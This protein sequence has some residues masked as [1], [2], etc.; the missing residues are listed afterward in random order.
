M[1]LGEA[2][3]YE[4]IKA[5]KPFVGA[6]GRELDR[7]LQDSGI[8]RGD[9]WVSNVSKYLVPFNERGDKIPF[10]VRAKNVGI[11]LNKELEDLQNEINQIRPN[12]I[13]AL[14]NTALWALSGKT[15]ISQ[16]RGSILH[17][18][19]RKFVST[20]HPA[21]LLHNSKVGGVKG[22]WNRQIM[23]L[24]M[25]RVKLQSEFPE[26]RL[27]VR[28]LEICRSSIQLEEFLKQYEGKIP[29]VD[30]EAGGHCLPVCI[31]LAFNKSHGMT[32]PL[33][34]RDGIST[35]HDNELARIWGLLSDI[36]WRVNGVIGQNFNYDRDKILRLGFQVKR[37]KEDT[38]FKAFAINPELPKGLAFNTSIYTEEPYYKDEG[39]YEGSYN[40]L[41]TGCARDSCVTRELC[42]NMDED[43]DGINQRKYYENYLMKLPYMYWKIEQQGFAIDSDRRNELLRKYIERDEKLR[44]DMFKLVGIEVNPAS[45]KQM[46][47]LLFEVMKLP[48][49]TSTGEE[50]LTELLNSPTV[51]KNEEHV[52]ILENILETRRVRRTISSSVMA[53]PDYDG[54]LRT[55]Y[56]PCLETGRS[57]T[58]MQDPPIRPS[59]ELRDENWKKK[60]KSMGFP[61][62]TITKHG[63]I[64]ADVREMLLP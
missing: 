58:S 5:R 41:F 7:L 46:H 30:I 63:D 28:N 37:V 26:L 50:A 12:I 32:V 27:P 8:N 24:D 42:D 3:G 22:Y 21:E 11:D 39:M 14:G 9:C 13:L 45:P 62:Q 60:D 43:L 2:P 44:Y 29:A 51:Q 34:N 16:F 23:I 40:D 1:I 18:M 59:I 15:K 31:G 6:S 4:E 38:M 33:W 10:T 17:G 48:F 54:R 20:Y 61:F 53:L 47:S 64:G 35:L 55:T 56:F 19:G 36:L 57:S 52:Q 25:K 49:K